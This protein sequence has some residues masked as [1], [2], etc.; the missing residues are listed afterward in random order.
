MDKRRLQKYFV[1]TENDLESNRRNEFSDGQKKRLAFEARA[2]QKTSR[3]S[4][5]IL[6]VIALIGMALGFAL[7]FIAPVGIGRTLLFS[8]M[9]F[10]WPVVWAGKGIQIIRDARALNEPA[11]RSVSGRVH[12]THLTNEDHILQ[13]GGMEFDLEGN[14]S[15]VIIEGDELTVYYLEATEEILSVSYSKDLT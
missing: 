13:L 9:G 5:I 10:L 1:F 14:P 2:E 11:L 6:F 8:T 3:D 12:L 15:G 7:G 4:A